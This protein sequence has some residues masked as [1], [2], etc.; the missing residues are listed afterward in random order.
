MDGWLVARIITHSADFE[1]LW[2]GRIHISD[3][4]HAASQISAPEDECA[5]N[6]RWVY[7]AGALLF[8]KD[9]FR[10]QMAVWRQ[11]EF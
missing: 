1:A 2:L 3:V 11:T 7:P 6:P 5:V 10:A 9:M 8:H 4:S